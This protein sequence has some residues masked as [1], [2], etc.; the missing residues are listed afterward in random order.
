MLGFLHAMQQMGQSEKKEGLEAYLVRPM[1][2]NGKEIRVWLQ[3]EGDLQ[4]MLDVVGVSRIDLADYSSDQALLN[5]YLYKKPAGSNTTWVFSPI[6][7]AGKMKNDAVKNREAFCPPKWEG[8]S[9][10]H[11][12]KIRNR[13]LM[14]YEK[15][16]VL[17]LGSVD[18]IMAGMQDKIS[19]VLDDLDNQQS[20]IVIF[21]IEHK[22]NLLYPGEVPAL[23]NY[24]ERKLEQ[25]LGGR[26]KAAKKQTT[27]EQKC[28]ICGMDM[29]GGVTLDKVFK[30]GTFDKVSFLAGLDKKEIPYS[31][32]VCQPCFEEISAGREKVDR[33]L[34]KRGLLSDILVWAIP[35]AVGVDS[36][37]L[38]T[39]FLHSWEEKME[40][41][42]IAGM[43]EKTEDMYFSR[44]AK[45][46]QGL[47]FH[48]VFWEKNN[49]Q[50]IVHLMVED[51]P[52]ER[53]AHL[54]TI[55]QKVNREFSAWQK[56]TDLDTA[57]KSLYA[58]M[59][60]FSGKS[61]GDKK[62][63]RDFSLK[64]IGHMLRGERLPVDMFKQLIVPRLPRLVFE[65]NS[66]TVGLSMRYAELWVEYMN[67]LNQEV[68]R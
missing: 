32:P 59:N 24:F 2:Q 42:E 29:P 15:E 67:Q 4:N 28:S 18:S 55:W 13:I 61:S 26:D 58:T 54:E 31:F 6:H 62:V 34:T 38:F 50:E 52:P 43:G 27:T 46:G 35:E 53:L 11:F 8:N 63:F 68:S 33:V 40:T 10:S 41:R 22:G 25:N 48:F 60:A 65:G 66:S 37:R 17:R 36:N 30:F 57:I 19:M 7:K 56:P 45:T 47:I 16:S 44:L 12:Y 39:H 9:K 5:K 64:V 23:V 20:Y 21:V 51:V 3:V 49:A 14:D 1:D